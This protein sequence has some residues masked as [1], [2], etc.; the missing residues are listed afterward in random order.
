MPTLV[1]DYQDFGPQV[2]AHEVIGM[3]W[4]QWDAHGDPDPDSPDDV[5]IVVYRGISA[6]QVQEAFP[7]VEERQQD[8]RYLSY[9]D[10]IA[11]LR[12]AIE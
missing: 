9:A 8:Y 12:G 3:A 5:K 7:V 6:E 4:W 10:A 11:Y 1:L 2:A